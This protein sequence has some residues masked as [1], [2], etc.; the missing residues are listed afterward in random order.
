MLLESSPILFRPEILAKAEEISE[1]V[2]ISGSSEATKPLMKVRGVFQRYDEKN[3]NGRIYP[4]ELFT[5][6]LNEES[7]LTRLKEN[8]VLG[9][10][11]HPEDGITRLTGPISHIVT[12]AW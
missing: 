8:S 9:M 4:K 6:C 1:D 12:K 3:A 11:E 7:W 2:Q 5:R 10:I